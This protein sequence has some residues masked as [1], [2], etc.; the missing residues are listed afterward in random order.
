MVPVVDIIIIHDPQ[1]SISTQIDADRPFHRD[2]NAL[3]QASEHRSDRG[4]RGH[5]QHNDWFIE[6]ALAH[7]FLHEVEMLP[8][9]Q[10]RHAA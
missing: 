5:A 4:G 1:R 3:R 2:S 8:A 9:H 7:E 6:S 10:L